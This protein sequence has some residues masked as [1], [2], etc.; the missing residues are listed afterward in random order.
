[1]VEDDGLVPMMLVGVEKPDSTEE[2]RLVDLGR[3]VS[4]SR[5]GGS[6]DSDGSGGV[7][8]ESRLEAVTMPWPRAG[9]LISSSLICLVIPAEKLLLPS[10]G[11]DRLPFWFSNA[12]GCIDFLRR[13]PPR[14]RIEVSTAYVDS[15]SQRSSRSQLI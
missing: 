12:L 7:G 1:M 2:A 9:V 5:A 8:G 15:S 14:G 11:V 4:A 6:D 3:S 13:D 10:A